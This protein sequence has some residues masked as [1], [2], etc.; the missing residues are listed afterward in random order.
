MR[1]TDAI[2]FLSSILCKL[3]HLQIGTEGQGAIIVCG[4]PSEG[5]H[6]PALIDTIAHGG[7]INPQTT[8]PEG[9]QLVDLCQ[10]SSHKMHKGAELDIQQLV[11]RATR[12]LLK[13]VS[14]RA[15]SVPGAYRR[16]LGT[17]PGWWTRGGVVGDILGSK[18]F[19]D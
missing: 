19:C 5:T 7:R 14:R 13:G 9:A 4:I 3:L 12:S 18:R 15:S 6:A 2:L 10:P 8:D 1:E 11:E 16:N 17:R